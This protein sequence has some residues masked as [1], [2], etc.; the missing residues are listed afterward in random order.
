[1]TEP[2]RS[3][4]SRHLIV[5]V[6]GL[7]ILVVLAW[8]WLVMG[9]GM[10]M[11]AGRAHSGQH[12][13]GMHGSA[14]AMAMGSAEWTA[15]RLTLTFAMW[16]VMMVAMMLPSAAAVI[17]LYD[18]AAAGQG[19]RPATG[20]FL[21]GYLAVWA[22]FAAAATAL[23]SGLE[24][25]GLL[26]GEWMRSQS[27]WLTAALLILAGVYQLSPA[28]AAC[29]KHCQSPAQF[30]SRYYREGQ[31]GAARMGAIHGAFCVGCCWS[32]MALLFVGGVMN[33]AWIAA[34][35]VLVAAEKLLPI[36]RAIPTVT[37]AAL[38]LA[39]LAWIGTSRMG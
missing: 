39:G 20:Q 14:M 36:G 3:L 28:K 22:L 37:G 27:A 6:A 16:W 1:M 12:M 4:L 13:D 26:S 34:L 2:L 30:I 17:L 19:V 29:L 31:L 38:I 8:T 33:L 5:T 24:R 25:S 32:L 11:N 7:V 21:A 18:R 10:E 23:H 15:A 35:T 9:A